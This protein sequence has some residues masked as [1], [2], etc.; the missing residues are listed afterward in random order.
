MGAPCPCHDGSDAAQRRQLSAVVSAPVPEA[1]RAGAVPSANPLSIRSFRWLWSTALVANVG[2]WLESIMA[3]FVMAQMTSV[4][5]LVAA[6]PVAFGLPGVLLALPSGATADSVDRRLVLLWAKALFFAALAGLAALTAVGGLSPFALL[7]FTVLLGVL[8]AF[9]SP[10]WWATL[11]DLVP[12][13]LLPAA[14]SLDG[15]EWNVGQIAGPLLGGV[16]LDKVGAG[17]MFAVAA[18]LMA[19]LVAFLFVWRGRQAARLSTPGAGATERMT[20][21]VAAGL[22]Y[23]ANAPALQVACWRTIL[24]ILPA[25]A[26][27]ALLPLVAARELHLGAVGYGLLLACV[28]V[29]SVGAAVVLY[30]A[31]NHLHLDAMLGSAALVSSAATVLL[32]VFRDRYLSALFLAVTGAAW[33][34]SVTALNLGVQQAV[35]KWILSR[36]LGVYLAVYQASIVVGALLWGGLADGVGVRNALIVAGA[37]LLPGVVLIRWL[38]L[39]V[40]ARSDMQVV[41]RPLPD[42][43]SEP[44]DEDG[45]VLIVVTYVV[46]V[47]D[48]DQFVEAMEELRVV[49]RRTG[50]T[51][52]SLFEDANRPGRFIESFVTASW[53]AYLMQRNRY[54]KADLRVL[55]AAFALH[56]L[57]EPPEIAYYVHPDSALAYR[58]LA[59]WRRLRGVDRSLQPSWGGAPPAPPAPSAP[60]SAPSAPSSAP[61]GT[62]SS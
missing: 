39:P 2:V 31:G 36:A 23:L 56:T 27:P 3:G 1:A 59:R 18:A 32:V 33:L 11:R 24:F 62:E 12:E 55:G 58:R 17:A 46:D 5:S 28:G 37:A 42:M 52:W 13:R 38:G 29:G 21:A 6:L 45:P 54:T 44:E 14:I 41:P 51:R 7:V 35:P 43:V 47:D 20:G 19:G 9:S 15:L 49:R 53:A 34:V 40:V 48:R 26:L 25:G 50:A 10:A 57:P 22:R 4:P 60:S 61:P 30:R 8:S 16:L